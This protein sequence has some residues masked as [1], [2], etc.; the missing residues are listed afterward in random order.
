MGYNE[1]IVVLILNDS[2]EERGVWNN[3]T[4]SDRN[5]YHLLRVNTD[6]EAYMRP[7]MLSEQCQRASQFGMAVQSVCS[8][9]IPQ[10]NSRSCLV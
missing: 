1:L 6:E 5:L 7:V 2:R 9:S 8:G 10:P 3:F 4:G